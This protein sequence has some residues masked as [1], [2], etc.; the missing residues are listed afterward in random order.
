VGGFNFEL[1]SGFFPQVEGKDHVEKARATDDAT[2]DKIL[3]KAELEAKL[4]KL[5]AEKHRL[6]QMLKQVLQLIT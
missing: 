3:K 6:V 1:F 4:K 2:G 5:T